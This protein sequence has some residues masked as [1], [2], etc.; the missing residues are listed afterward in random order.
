MA[1][2][3]GDMVTLIQKKQTISKQF[4][5]S[6]SVGIKN[7]NIVNRAET[8]Y[9]ALIEADGAFDAISIR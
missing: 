5:K 6:I 4:I 2:K 8:L 1:I 9:A 3:V 7:Q